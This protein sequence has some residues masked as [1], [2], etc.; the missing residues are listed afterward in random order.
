MQWYP[1]QA[2]HR[3]TVE[4]YIY[5]IY[6][7]KMHKDKKPPSQ[8][9]IKIVITRSIFLLVPI[10]LQCRRNIIRRKQ[11]A[12]VGLLRGHY[13]TK[14]ISASA[15][16]SAST[17]QRT[18]RHFVG[19]KQNKFARA[20]LCKLLIRRSSYSGSNMTCSVVWDSLQTVH[21]RMHIAQ[22]HTFR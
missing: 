10:C 4:E 5:S 6:C 17:C 8:P 12:G 3:L 13:S 2:K 9:Y 11:W 18:R 19:E 1:A 22:W 20:Q 16:L 15:P 7:I 14:M 21:L